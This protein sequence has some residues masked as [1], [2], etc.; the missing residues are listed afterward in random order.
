MENAQTLASDG[1]VQLTLLRGVVAICGQGVDQAAATAL[2]SAQVPDDWQERRR[3]RDGAGGFHLTFLTK[4]DMQI[5]AERLQ[6]SSGDE[7]SPS[8][9]EE[10]PEA[11]QRPNPKDL[12]SVAR[13][14][15]ALVQ[16]HATALTWAP[17]G[18]GRARDEGSEAAFVAVAWPAGAA[19]RRKLGLDPLDFHITLGF[20]SHDIH[21][22]SKGVSTVAGGV[23]D[24]QGVHPLASLARRL[25]DAGGG[26][27][28]TQVASELAQLALQGAQ[29][30][31]DAAGEV[32]A[33]EVLCLLDGLLK[34]PDLV[35]EHAGA[36][37]QVQT[38]N[39]VALRS[40][41]FALFMLR[42]FKEA[43]P[44][45]EQAR[46]RLE[47]ISDASE[48][49]VVQGRV[50]KCLE[51]CRKKLNLSADSGADDDEAFEHAFLEQRELKFPSTSHI[52]N[53]GAATKDDKICDDKRKN[54]FIGSGRIVTVEEKIDGANLGIS[55]DSQYRPRMQG[56]SKWVNWNTDPQFGG[57]EQWLQEHA[58]TLCELLERNRHVLFGEWCQ[59]LHTVKYTRLPGYFVAFD[60]YDRQAG[61][62]LSRRD[63]HA[64]LRDAAGPTIPAV[65]HIAHQAFNSME[66]VEALLERP[67]AF[68]GGGVLVEGVYL[69]VDE[70]ASSEGA[71]TFLEDR[72]KL[73]RSDFRHAVDTEGSWRGRGR[74]QLDLDFAMTY[75]T[76]CFPLAGGAAEDEAPE[77][78]GG[79][80]SASA[81]ESGEVVEAGMGPKGEGKD[82]YPSTPHLPFSP[83][84]NSDDVQLADCSALISSE[85]VVTEKLDGGNCCIKEGQVYARTHGQPAT[86]ES[87]SAVK[88]I[89]NAFGAALDGIELYGEN[90]AGIHS[91]QYGNL[92]SFLYVFAARR[93]GDWLAWDEVEALAE[94][95]GLPTV[96][97]VFR[98]RFESSQ[99]LQECFER[100][101]R[102]PSAVGASTCPEG[103]VVRHVAVM[104]AG[105]FGAH[106]AKYVRANHI[107][108]DSS[109]KRT[110]KKAQLGNALPDRPLRVLADPLRAKLSDPRV[111]HKVTVKSGAEVELQRNFSFM[112]DD[113][114]V[115]STPKKKEQILAMGGLG[116]SLVVTLTEE[117]P[118]PAA[119]FEK[120]GVT[121]LF[122]AVT[123]YEPP[124]VEQMDQIIDAITDVVKSGG[125]VMVHCGGGKGRAGTV[126]ACLLLRFGPDSIAVGC[127]GA[128][129]CHMQSDQVLAYLRE[130][131]PGSVETV[132]QER[133]I[134][135]YASLLW[136]RAA[137][138]PQAPSDW[139]AQS[140]FE[141]EALVQAEL[142]ESASS[143]SGDRAGGGRAHGASASAS[144]G[145]RFNPKARREGKELERMKKDVAKR[146]PKY[147][148]MAGLAGAGKSTFSRML[149]GVGCWVRAN[150][151]DFK[152]KGY[153][154]LL[155]QTVPLVRQGRTHLVVDRCNLTKADRAEVLDMLGSPPA[156][157]VVCV[158]Y[159]FPAADCKRRAAARENHPTIRKGGGARIIDAQAKQLE[160]PA[161]A[162]GFSRVEV[163]TSFQEA[164]A[165]LQRYGVDSACIAAARGAAPE[166]PATAGAAGADDEESAAGAE[167]E[168]LAPEPSSLPTNFTQWLRTALEEELPAVDAESIFMAAEV[169]LGNADADE[170]ALE[171][172]VQVVGDAGAPICSSGLRERWALAF[173]R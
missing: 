7:A 167:E 131:R 17:V 6:D 146:A 125:K 60:I 57:L 93:A 20:S 78:A 170:E 23:P 65:P 102:E 157:E 105:S 73:V 29:T 82:N 84:V 28:E 35:L 54:F 4:A 62:F 165:L 86:H 75:V 127:A 27:D 80:G 58:E 1:S 42:R 110:W 169:I 144:S 139:E 91:I 100:W 164:E 96:P 119:W 132:R 121:N 97:V 76:Q 122:V 55:L 137:D 135:E 8:W 99:Q 30:H 126:A 159:D 98:G 2:A 140:E 45:L 69:R 31:G 138:E 14:A 152:R 114:A 123:N 130:R 70:M 147:I 3:K 10:L 112:Q 25:L 79:L 120:T 85:V 48:R 9:L 149:E 33:L 46:G 94:Q 107:Q 113:V 92:T 24:T 50:Q 142:F 56:R 163:I 83:G 52:K 118:L 71:P 104:P 72:C 36:L 41:A 143:A 43:L 160:R 161:Q 18:V 63:F 150:Q 89:A 162:E 37:L 155:R 117:E 26:P 145:S 154:D 64:R 136:Q 116:I 61:R 171:S 103:F 111:R 38:G 39:E 87:F 95:L 22:R 59:Y 19:V 67:A 21:G 15:A 81:A 129:R 66:E 34:K 11:A 101:A 12:A 88:Q 172:A 106:I 141:A 158:F 16:A 115:S 124:T 148:V 133:F 32:A 90:M 51:M 151:D 77:A 128:L 47:L 68:G 156:R 109:W 153:E 173:P 53:L 74:N 40:R 44:A 108:T 134:R 13:A 166:E 5:A 168:P 49:S